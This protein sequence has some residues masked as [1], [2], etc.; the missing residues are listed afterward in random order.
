M[1]C[2]TPKPSQ[3]N[4]EIT[5]VSLWSPSS[6]DLNPLDY[7]IWDVLENQTNATSHPGIHSLNIVI[8]EEWNEMSEE[9]ILKRRKSFRKFVDSI[10]EKNNGHID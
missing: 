3:Q 5:G 2:L 8:E 4:F 1:T 6:S 9:F 10:I 7:A